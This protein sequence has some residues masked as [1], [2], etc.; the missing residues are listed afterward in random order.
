MNANQLKSLHYYT[1]SSIPTPLSR[2]YANTLESFNHEKSIKYPDSITL[3]RMCQKCSQVNIPGINIK[4]RLRKNGLVYKC[5]SCKHVNR[6]KLPPTASTA[7]TPSS[8]TP[9]STT[10][11]STTASST[12]SK[13]KRL[14]KKSLQALLDQKKQLT[15]SGSLNLMEF[16]N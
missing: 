5:M 16:M 13:K 2:Y 8:T 12:T 10:A 15:S 4:V 3:G 9:S 14:K 1:L 7:S 11:S 6:Y